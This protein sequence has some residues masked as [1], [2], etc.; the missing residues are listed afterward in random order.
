MFNFFK[1]KSKDPKE[2]LKRLIG[3]YELPS[4]S[5][6][7]INILSKLRSPG[8]SIEEVSQA[9]RV[10][11]STHLKVLKIVNSAAFGLTTNV[12]NLRHAIAMLGKSHLETIVLSQAVNKILPKFNP[13]FFDLRLFWACSAR[14]ASFARCFAK[15]FQPSRQM[16]AFTIGLLQDI[17]LLVL[18]DAK[19][20]VYSDIFEIWKRDKSAVLHNLE[21]DAL[22]FDHYVVGA[23]LAK[24]WNLPKVITAGLSRSGNTGLGPYFSFLSLLRLENEE[25]VKESILKIFCDAPFHLEEKLVA[26]ITSEALEA[27]ED[28]SMLLR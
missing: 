28:L 18:V 1:R 5:G 3:D 11:P 4:F 21:N 9:I 26:S 15:H 7:V 23:I 2:E 25:A 12:E 13:P 19:T 20:E 14:R 27:A 17:A 6:A 24:E 8:F 10:D 16:D 22:G